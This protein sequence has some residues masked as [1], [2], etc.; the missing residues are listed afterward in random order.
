MLHK[1]YLWLSFLSLLLSCDD[2]MGCLVGRL[3]M[4]YFHWHQ[5]ALAINLA[6]NFTTYVVLEQNL[7]CSEVFYSS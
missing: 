3:V 1:Y 2:D 7:H 6:L 5:K 4:W